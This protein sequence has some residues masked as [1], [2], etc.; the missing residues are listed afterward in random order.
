VSSGLLTWLLTPWPPLLSRV[1]WG[2]YP[3]RFVAG[4]A[5]VVGMNPTLR[6]ALTPALSRGEREGEQGEAGAGVEGTEFC[7]GCGRRRGAAAVLQW[8]LQSLQWPLRSL[9]CAVIQTLWR[10]GWGRWA[11]AGAGRWIFL[12]GGEK[13]CEWGW[14]DGRV[15][16]NEQRTTRATNNGQRAPTGRRCRRC[17]RRT[18]LPRRARGGA[19]GRR[20]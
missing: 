6:C 20:R 9:Q 4:V 10:R 13:R 18:G 11:L 19:A 7:A 14:S 8:P 2:F 15:T 3:H 16:S 5:G 1:G 12:D 17:G